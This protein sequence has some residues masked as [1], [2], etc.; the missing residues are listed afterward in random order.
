[1]IVAPAIPTATQKIV[2][3]PRQRQFL[4]CQ[5]D[6]VIYG[7]TAGGGKTY[8]EL[9]EPLYHIDNP[10]FGAVIFRRTIPEVT[11]EG[12]LWDEA[13]KLYPL[14]GA[15]DNK[16]E[17]QYT[18]MTGARVSFS[19]MQR[20]EDKYA[21]KSAQVP[22][23]EFD[24]LETF[25]ASQFWYMLSRNRSTCGVK[26]YMRATANA[27]PGWLAD[28][29]SWWIA[30]DGYAILERSGVIRYMARIGSNDEIV[31]GDSRQ[32]LLDKYPECDPKSFTFILATLYDNKI[33]MQKDPGY[34]ANL[35]NLP[36]V[37]RE[38]LLGDPVRGGN[39]KIKPSAGKVF[40]RAW[41]QPIAL[42]DVPAGGVVCRRWDFAA[43]EKELNK[44][45][46]DST[47]STLM[48]AVNN[49]YYILDSTNDQI[50]PSQIDPMFENITRQDA[51]QFSQSGRRYMARW[52]QE[53]GSAGKR[54][55]WRTTVKFPGI[56]AK[57]VPAIHDKL[58]NWKPFATMAENGHN[59]YYVIEP[60][61]ERF[62][63]NL[64]GVPDLD[65]D[66]DAD[67]ASGAF[68]DLAN[69]SGTISGV[70]EDWR[71]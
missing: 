52:E 53:P 15:V 28:L 18:F 59:V 57:G 45:D 40:N 9:L 30:E 33:L 65:H 51:A 47:S 29:I 10:D 68:N 38:R 71:E 54:E 19:H 3:Q 67:S 39:W 13:G 55:S 7:G 32:E 48:L 12:G 62:L 66:D 41:F 5:A 63:N 26:P 70:I 64:H 4:T 20:E 60:W 21:W 43:T 23:I 14:L 50:A 49:C 8:A 56:D 36:Y 17:H 31:W 11:N 24:Q 69:S 22:L 46:P 34:L 37:E 44:N 42:K 27:E 25:T 58:T 2:P 16:N 6:I 35:K 61:N 1:M